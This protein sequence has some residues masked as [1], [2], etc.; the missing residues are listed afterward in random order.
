MTMLSRDG[1]GE[2]GISVGTRELTPVDRWRDVPED[3]KANV[4]RVLSERGAPDGRDP[5]EFDLARLALEY[6]PPPVVVLW[7][8]NGSL[9]G[10]PPNER[11]DGSGFE[12]ADGAPM[13]GFVASG[14]GTKK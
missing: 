3:A 14:P 10:P 4:L 6:A 12:R 7:A 11:L 9:P 2:L 13:G 8:P 1:A 5:N